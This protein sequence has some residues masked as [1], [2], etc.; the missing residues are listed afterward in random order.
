MEPTARQRIA[1]SGQNE[2]RTRFK[3]GLVTNM[4]LPPPPGTYLFGGTASDDTNP[5]PY[6]T[7]LISPLSLSDQSVKQKNLSDNSP[8][9]PFQVNLEKNGHT[10]AFLVVGTDSFPI[11][12]STLMLKPQKKFQFF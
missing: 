8:L 6:R 3:G 12:F 7:L 5:S 2:L 1:K 11:F 4:S 10:F 9:Q